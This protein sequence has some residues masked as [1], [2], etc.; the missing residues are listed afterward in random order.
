MLLI[1]T[2]LFA[3][4]ALGGLTMVAIKVSGKAIPLHLIV[5]HGLLAVAGL[6]TLFRHLPSGAGASPLTIAVVIFI[7]ALGLLFLFAFL[8]RR[9]PLPN[10][11]FL[12]H[13]G[14]AATVLV[15]LLYALMLQ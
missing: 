6:V 11:L 15:V 5:G 9:R 3:L 2:A 12:I 1:A 7:F 8:L 14:V 13:G 10:P 4:S